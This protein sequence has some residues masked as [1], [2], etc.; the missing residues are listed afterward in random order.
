M[1]KRLRHVQTHEGIGLLS[2]PGLAPPVRVSYR[3]EESRE[4]TDAGSVGELPGPQS[5]EGRILDLD[6]EMRASLDQNELTLHLADGRVLAL[7][8]ERDGRIV[9]RGEMSSP[10]V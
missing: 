3:I 1:G 6:A 4:F 5:L 7:Q 8:L 9:A 10:P 2:G